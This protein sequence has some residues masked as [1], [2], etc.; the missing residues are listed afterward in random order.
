VRIRL[1]ELHR[2]SNRN[3]IAHVSRDPIA[4][5]SYVSAPVQRDL[6]AIR[7]PLGH[8]VLTDQNERYQTP[9]FSIPAAAVRLWT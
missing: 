3:Q 1:R 8:P 6:P 9:R 4:C 2:S 7:H 5:G